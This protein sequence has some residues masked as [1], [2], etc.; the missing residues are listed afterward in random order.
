MDNQSNSLNWFE[1][2]VTDI[3]RATV[4]YQSIFDITLEKVNMGNLEMAFFPAEPG[5]GKASGGL[6]KSQMHV[7]SKEGSI[8]YLNANPALDNVLA[9]I[10]SAGGEVVVPKTQITE[11]IG[12]MAFFIDTEGNKVALHSQA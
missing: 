7:P 9:R 12:Y 5:S 8:I 2:P 11:E 1:I 6:A 4:F 10:E 3:D